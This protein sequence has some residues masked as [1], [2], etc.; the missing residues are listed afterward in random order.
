[1]EPTYQ[2]TT[3]LSVHEKNILECNDYF[4]VSTC[5]ENDGGGIN[6]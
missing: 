1:M 2:N 4:S 3:T 5:G 6:T